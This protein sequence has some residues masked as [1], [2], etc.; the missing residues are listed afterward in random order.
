MLVGVTVTVTA[1]NVPAVTATTTRPATASLA[2]TG[3]I[4][5]LGY[6]TTAARASHQHLGGNCRDD[7]PL[8]RTIAQCLPHR[9][10]ENHHDETEA[11]AWPSFATAYHQP[12]KAWWVAGER[13]IRTIQTYVGFGAAI[14]LGATLEDVTTAPLSRRVGSN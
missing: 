7:A 9:L 4:G 8:L 6:R 13:P 10:G 12:L 3:Q 11:V 2:A 5:P 1:T 14:D